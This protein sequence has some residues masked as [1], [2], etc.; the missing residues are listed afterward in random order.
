MDVREK[1]CTG[2]ACCMPV[3][4]SVTEQEKSGTC[5]RCPYVAKCGED[6]VELP[7][8]MVMDIRTILNA[9]GEAKLLD[10][11]G[12]KSLRECDTFWLEYK[13][14][15]IAPDS[16]AKPYD[17]HRQ[18]RTVHGEILLKRNLGTVYRIWTAM[19]SNEQRDKEQWSAE[20]NE[21]ED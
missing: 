13:N 21:S 18:F 15:W 9:M 17:N 5:E 4:A 20:N 12:V 19:P 6:F 10:W 2:L 14:G 7:L 11:E 1:A 8:E 16:V 3:C